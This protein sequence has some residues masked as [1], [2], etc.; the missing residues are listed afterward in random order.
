MTSLDHI[1][2]A[3]ADLPTIKKLFSLLSLSV[4]HIENVQDQGV[5]AH[6]ILLP[7][8]QSHL[9]FLEITDPKGTVAKFIQKR[10]PGIH[11]L[12][13][14]LKAGE[15]EPLCVRIRQEG[16]KLVYDAPQRGANGMVVNFIHPS[17]SGGILIELIEPKK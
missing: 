2:I 3:V 16:F 4:S 5:N 11:H 12:S 9:E 1:G 8:E 7:Q 17:S 6:F 15:L 14:R 13:F 10:G